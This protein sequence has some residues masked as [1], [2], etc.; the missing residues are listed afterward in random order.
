MRM[1]DILMYIKSDV[2]SEIKVTK[3]ENTSWLIAKAQCTPFTKCLA[4]IDRTQGHI[5]SFVVVQEW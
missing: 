1:I 3:S 5:F 2:R 4:I